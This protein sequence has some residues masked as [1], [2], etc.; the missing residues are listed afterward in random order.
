M[1]SHQG[2]LENVTTGEEFINYLYGDSGLQ[3]NRLSSF[4]S[5][6]VATADWDAFALRNEAGNTL[7]TYIELSPTED[8]PSLSDVKQYLQRQG[9]DET[10][11][12]AVI[13]KRTAEG[14][15]L[16]TDIENKV[17]FVRVEDRLASDDVDLDFDLRIFEFDKTDIEPFYLDYLDDLT[18][19]P[20]DDLKS[21]RNRAE[22]TFSLKAVTK[23]FYEEFGEIF[24]DTLQEAIHGLNIE[25][26]G[27]GSYT[28]LV[29]NRILF[30]MFVQQ[31]GWLNENTTYVQDRYEVV[32]ADENK[33]VYQDLFSPLFFD[34]LNNPQQAEFDDLGTIPYFNGG[35]FEQ[36]EYEKDVTIDEEFFDALLDPEEDQDTHDTKGFLRRY[37]ISL[38]ESNPSEQHLVVDPEFI[39]RIFEAFMQQED[40]GEKGLF[41][42]PK[43]ITQYMAKNSL[44]HYLF[45]DFGDQGDAIIQLV[46]NH[47]VSGSLD[48]LTVSE[49]R[50]KLK[51]ISI[52]DPA[53]GSGAFMIAMVEELVGITNV[54][55]ESLGIEEHPYELKEEYIAT[56]LYGVDI[57][58][59]GIEL[60][61]FRV[62]LNL[63]QD[64]PADLDDFVENNEKYALPNLGLKFFVGN[65]LVG[66][67][68]PTE[69][70]ESLSGEEGGYQGKLGADFNEDSLT[71]RI[72]NL[73]QEYIYAHGDHKR[74]I[75]NEIKQLTNTLD[76]KVSWDKSDHWMK[77]VVDKA[78]SDA[79]F[80]WSINFP[81]VMLDDDD[82]AG[83]D[84]VIGNPPYRG[85]TP[86]YI[87]ELSFFLEEHHDAY[88]MPIGSRRYDLYQKFIFRGEELVREGGIFSYIT[89]DTFRTISTKEA[90]R[91]LLQ[92]NRLEEILV[93][94]PDT[95]DAA[96][97]ASIF[98]LRHEDASNRNYEL[99]YVNGKQTPI[100]VYRDLIQSQPRTR[101]RSENNGQIRQI[102]T[103]HNIPSY[104]IPIE[105]YRS[106]IR[107]T[108]FEPT[109]ENRN[110]YNQFIRPIKNLYEEWDDELSDINEL[111][112][113]LSA[114]QSQ[115]IDELQPG[116]TSVLGLLTWGGVG[117]ST[118]SNEDHIAY[119]E[120]TDKAKEVKER[121]GNDFTYV[122]KNE[123]SYWYLSRVIKQEHTIHP[124]KLTKDEKRNGIQRSKRGEQVWLPYE[125]GAS[126]EDRFSK[127]T[128]TYIDWSRESLTAISERKDGR[129][130]EPEIHFRKGLFSSRG[131]FA[132]LNV[133]YIENAAVDTT[134]AALIPISEKVPSKYLCGI[135]NTEIASDIIETFINESG[136]QINDMRLMPIPV[137]T[138]EQLSSIVDLVDQA[139]AI[140]NGKSDKDLDEV[141]EKLESEVR[142][143]YELK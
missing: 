141:Q 76:E 46:A 38:S 5:S 110:I 3:Y 135:L 65:S 79:A 33:D 54:I 37:K 69:V 137:P 19:K 4:D 25:E 52:I 114:V 89:S 72:A 104:G 113:N 62:W 133:R 22:D 112:D 138:S 28:Q 12:F 101:Q 93:T 2:I 41:Y 83:F 102:D 47:E 71:D 95:F 26:T 132:N 140:K 136:K 84:I 35:L 68:E 116:D 16:Q 91:N 39:G 6:G 13:G 134:G 43:P 124:E 90:T 125:K 66:D 103:V 127:P 130:R 121:N 107:K 14:T 94:N 99:L 27:K 67:Y 74:A 131:G 23:R 32:R 59:S 70:S 81:E 78:G 9:Q 24:Q 53:V 96:V 73:R 128:V 17:T 87:S 44:K 29:V 82:T 143:I 115:H 111:S 55:N 85:E 75:E 34:A 106:N 57:D 56:S 45:E 126:E 129:L 40:R 120:G 98:T 8:T 48:E 122:D 63:M 109:K 64:L 117:M 97:H 105:V 51:K 100:N 139:I 60:C 11:L 119:L 50:R 108:F 142:K 21:L 7:I 58:P 61:K 123:E 92:K 30:L 36:K 31:K 18:V 86:D 15:F 10:E 118:A 42:T 1:S 49:I 77:D 88:E 80:K 20:S